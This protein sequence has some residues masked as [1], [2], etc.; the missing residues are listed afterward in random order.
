MRKTYVLLLAMLFAGFANAQIKQVTDV[1]ETGNAGIGDPFMYNGDL[2]FEADAGGEA[3]DELYRIKSD[4]TVELFMDINQ[5]AED[6]S[7]NSDPG[8]FIVFKSNLYFNANDGDDTGH[9]KELWVTDGTVANT[10]MVAD[11]YPGAGNGANPMD[12][13]IFNDVLYFQAKYESSTQ[14]WK[15]DGTNDP[16]KVTTLN[17]D[18]YATPRSPIVDT[19][20]NWV[21]F[22]ASNGR[23]ELHVMKADETIV[24]LDI[25]PNGHGYTGSEAILYDGKLIFQGDN[26]VEGDELWISDGTLEGTSMIMDIYEGA[27]DSNP[28]EFAIYNNKVYFV[29]EVT[30][31]TQLWETDGTAANTKMVAEPNAGA[32]GELSD[33][34][35]YNGKLYFAATDGTNG[36]ELWVYDGT[37]AAMLKDLNPEAGVGSDPNGFTIVDDLLLFEAN[38]SLYVTDGTTENTIIV[39]SFFENSENPVDVNAREFV[40]SGTELY[41]TADDAN[42]DEIFMVDAADLFVYD[43]T[44]NVT[45]GTNA[46]EGAEVAFN[47]TT[48]TTNANGV[49]VFEG[50]EPGTDLAYTVTKN[51][52]YEA[53]GTVNV[54]NG[55]VTE[56]VTMELA[57]TYAVTFNVTSMSTAIDG[58]F[59]E[60]GQ[61]SGT[62]NADGIITF[63]N[64]SV[65]NDIPY[66][67][68]MDGYNEATGAVSVV[69]ADVTENVEL[70]PITYT[71]TFNVSDATAALQGAEVA[72][73]ET[74]ATTDENGV[75]VFE[76]VLPANGLAYTITKDGYLDATGT[77]DVVDADKTVDVEMLT[78]GIKGANALSISVYP[79]PSVNTIYVKGA[80]NNS[81]FKIYDL[82]QRVVLAGQ[83]SSEKAI[84]HNLVSGLYLIHVKVGNDIMVEKIIVK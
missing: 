64:I 46:I 40:V 82:N 17:N 83:L 25:N 15:Y 34:F 68:T 81:T 70:T 30:T 33:L 71:V 52:Y 80:E 76:N 6:G 36:V 59:V 58:A 69:D 73:N 72:F 23:N 9:D 37:S 41:F 63:D 14:F 31:G 51:L 26:D 4:G 32:D 20:N 29:A 21:W 43:V 60:F 2:Y 39:A 16:V 77:V 11:I 27:E 8:N 74:T 56:E 28:E 5:D 61:V 35:V 78:D 18:G 38:D 12:L 57:P 50:V 54:A 84:K 45:D 13:F 55:P 53:T 66:T 79:N 42:G 47:E 7:P 65:A 10:K 3:G 75:A 1:N 44:F 24:E 19:A 48:V 49:A 62:T 22:Q 67:V